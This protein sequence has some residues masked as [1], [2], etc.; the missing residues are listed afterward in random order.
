MDQFEQHTAG[1]LFFMILHQASV[2]YMDPLSARQEAFSR[3]HLLTA[4]GIHIR[5][6]QP[7]VVTLTPQAYSDLYQLKCGVE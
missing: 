3:L 1:V 6:R 2:L 7:D 5:F 4:P